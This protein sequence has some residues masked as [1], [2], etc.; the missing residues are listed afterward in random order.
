MYA[1][2]CKNQNTYTRA[3]FIIR[4][5]NSKYPMRWLI[6]QDRTENIH[7][8]TNTPLP[9]GNYS[10]DIR[11]NWTSVD[12]KEYTVSLYSPYKIKLVDSTGKT[13]ERNA[14]LF[15]NNYITPDIFA[16]QTFI[17]D[18]TFYNQTNISIS[19]DNTSDKIN[20]TNTTDYKTNE[21]AYNS[22]SNDTITNSTNNETITNSTTNDTT[23]DSTNNETVANYTKN[24]TITDSTNNET[25]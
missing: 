13:K 6:A 25:I 18:T 19:D 15:V 17:N 4:Q 16:N 9:A 24:D 8:Y 5:R 10:I 2:G 11:V 23:T 21:T 7:N 20:T 14:N 12:L 1:K 22:T 3:D